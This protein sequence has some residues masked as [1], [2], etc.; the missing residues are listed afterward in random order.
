MAKRF[1]IL[2][3]DD[4]PVNI[5][6]I[7]SAL[8]GE[9]DILSSMNGY[10]AISQLKVQQPDLILLDVMMPG[11]SGFDVCSIIKSDKSIADIPVIFLTALTSSEDE[12]RGLELGGID[13]L[14]KPIN[15]SLLKLRVRNQLALKDRNELVKQQRDLLARQKKELEDKNNEL[16][17]FTYTVSHDL[18]SPLITIQTY[19]GMIRENLTAGNLE[20]TKADLM[21]LERAAGQMSAM[22]DDLLKLSRVG[23]VSSPE[24][25]IDMNR[26]VNDVL[27]LLVGPLEKRR[28]EIVVQPSLPDVSGDSQRLMTVIQNLVE[29][30]VKYMGDQSAPR[31]EIGTRKDG[32]EQIF[33]V[34]D[35]GIGIDPGCRE[36]IFGLFNKLDAKSEGTGIG[37]ALVKRI[38]EIHGGRVW[39]ESA[40]EG[41]G[42]CFCFTLPKGDKQ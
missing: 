2:V 14:T 41:K 26:L 10:D 28:T 39:V 7:I 38:I 22:L 23:R 4:E 30:A 19:A 17:R 16:E 18:K 6:L 20:H 31:I 12:I 29:N 11:L 1:K 13:Y 35:N 3:V 21:R 33:F 32:T 25:M 9:Y 15:F 36:I 24:A 34:S 40:G 42:A 37:L 5:M 27:A 8:E